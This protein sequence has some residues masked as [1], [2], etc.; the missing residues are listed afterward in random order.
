MQ[1][2]I[3]IGYTTKDSSLRVGI[4][5]GTDLQEA[6]DRW[7]VDR[8]R[9]DVPE[10]TILWIVNAEWA[11]VGTGSTVSVVEREPIPKWRVGGYLK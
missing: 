10:A 7:L 1:G 8:A 5:G 3:A 4:V 9:R 2:T 6:L 11:S